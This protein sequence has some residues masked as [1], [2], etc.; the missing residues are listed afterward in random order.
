MPWPSKRVERLAVES[1]TQELNKTRTK[2]DQKT[3]RKRCKQSRNEK[4]KITVL[5]STHHKHFLE[6]LLIDHFLVVS[7]YIFRWIVVKSQF[8]E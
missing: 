4:T 3:N 1:E 6:I 8:L 5:F 7:F 2:D